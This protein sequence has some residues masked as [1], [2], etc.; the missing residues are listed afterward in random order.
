[1][2]TLVEAITAHS[3]TPAGLDQLHGIL[4]SQDSFLAS[5]LAQLPNVLE[6]L[7]PTAHSLGYLYI[8]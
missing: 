3:G 7:D 2:E 6:T 1:M 5:N 8:L 4:K